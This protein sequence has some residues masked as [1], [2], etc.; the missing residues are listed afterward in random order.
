MGYV[1]SIA[2]PHTCFSKNTKQLKE[3]YAN[4]EFIVER[5]MNLESFRILGV[6]KILVD[7][8]WLKYVIEIEGYVPRV[9]KEFYA[10]L[11]EHID[12][13]GKPTYR[14]VYFRGHV[15]EFFPKVICDY[16]KIPLFN[17]DEFEKEYH[18]D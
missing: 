5:N 3:L 8:E 15:Y 1:T 18:I 2:H 12:F 9:V 14:K 16:L 4:R 10:N 11:S 6:R 17:L 13:L 7:N